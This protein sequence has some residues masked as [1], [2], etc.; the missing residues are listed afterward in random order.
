LED[1]VSKLI[2]N[3]QITDVVRLYEH[4]R[5]RYKD[6]ALLESL[7][8][9]HESKSRYSIIG[10]F[11]EEVLKG[12]ENKYYC[13]DLIEG[14]IYKV[15]WQEVFAKWIR[16]GKSDDILQTGVI[17][18]IGYDEK[19]SFDNFKI[20]K[21]KQRFPSVYLVRYSL[22]FFY[23][24][25]QEQSYWVY[26]Q[27]MN[28]TGFIEFAENIMKQEKSRFKVNEKEFYTYD[29]IKSDF[30]LD[31]YWDKVK[32]T[33]DY[34]RN[35]DIFQ[36][37]LTVRF[38]GAYSGDPFQLYKELRKKTPNPFFAYLDFDFPMIST[39][40]ERF[41]RIKDDEIVSNPIKGTIRCLLDGIDQR[42]ILENSSKDRS[43]NVMIVDLI[44]NDLGRVCEQGTVKVVSLCEICKFN[45]L[46]HLESIIKGKLK[47]DLSLLDILKATFPG[48]SI[49]GA[50]KIRAVEII[51]ELEDNS[52]GPY[53]GIIG[54]FG[55]SGYV[56]TAIAI[57]V[58]YFDQQKYYFHAGGGIVL[59]SNPEN[60]YKELL[61]KVESIRK[62][63]YEFTGVREGKNSLTERKI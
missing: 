29:H 62:S 24:R 11:P 53:T 60:E 38:S 16:L 7:G 9:Y 34:I 26:D 2:R 10:I 14:D 31:D 4:V 57:R 40:P 8:D 17:G 3:S 12:G 33:V 23:D 59:D 63:L 46:Y 44:R 41:F 28:C 39:S 21:I 49:T 20:K 56:D 54:F 43:E 45:H 6:T 13:Y 25:A 52:R 42:S 22:L 47:K 32:K 30:N 55:E 61:L 51:D 37:N 48:G 18:Y 5:Q 36:A 27:T 58:I 35:G 50:P 15:N 1:S 19:E